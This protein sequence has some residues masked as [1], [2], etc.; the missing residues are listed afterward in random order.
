M[1]GG[2]EGLRLSSFSW[3]HCPGPPEWVSGLPSDGQTCK[4]NAER[5]PFFPVHRVFFPA[6]FLDEM[7]SG[8]FISSLLCPALS[9]GKCASNGGVGGLAAKTTTAH[10]PFPSICNLNSPP[11]LAPSGRKEGGCLVTGVCVVYDGAAFSDGNDAI[12]PPF[13]VSPWFNTMDLLSRGGGGECAMGLLFGNGGGD[14]VEPSAEDDKATNALSP[15]VCLSVVAVCFFRLVLSS[16]AAASGA[17]PALV[18]AGDVLPVFAPGADV[19]RLAPRPQELGAGGVP[20]TTLESTRFHDFCRVLFPPLCD[21]G[22]SH[23]AV[24]SPPALGSARCGSRLEL[25]PG[26]AVGVARPGMPCGAFL[27]LDDVGDELE[28]VASGAV[29]ALVFAGDVLPVF[30]PGADVPRLAPRPQELGA[31]GVPATTLESTR[32]HDFC[33][34]L[35]PPLCDRGLSHV[36]VGSPPALGSARCGSRLEL[37]PGAAVGVACP[38]ILGGV[39]CF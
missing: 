6:S 31:G 2:H 22:L 9:L 12:V 36:A 5:V 37:P 34:V 17:V 35:F 4:D 24:G 33:R 16:S 13:F 25:P 32:F 38:G 28:A 29:P 18:F 14:C 21:R 8:V 26:A 15:L 10:I 27:G 23:V 39:M 19:P 7:S 30:A 11:L 20:A 1:A 3:F